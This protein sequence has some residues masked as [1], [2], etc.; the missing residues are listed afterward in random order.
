MFSISILIPVY[1]YDVSILLESLKDQITSNLT[2]VI[3]ID[4]CSSNSKI[5]ENNIEY[6]QNNHFQYDVNN[7]N[8]GRTKT[9]RKL[10]SKANAEKLLFIDV[11]TIVT[12]KD[13]LQKFINEVHNNDVVFGGISYGSLTNYN[14]SLRWKYGINRESRNLKQRN[15]TPYLSVISGCFLIDK[16]K[17][18]KISE[19]LNFNLYGMDVLFSYQMKKLN[20]NV[21]HIDNPI[22]HIGLEQNLDFI[23]KTEK[24][25]DTLTWLSQKKLIPSSYRPIQ[26][27]LSQLKRLKIHPIVGLL[28][29]LFR[30]L[31][32][33]QLSSKSPSLQLFDIYRLGYLCYKSSK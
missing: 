24:G 12:S 14:Y 1:N 11:D 13:F 22:I 3:I 10:A 9:R 32:I 26:I 16:S 28:F 8:L 23:K 25:L 6:C 27:K 20:L 33:K 4:D 21:K 18:L 5:T 7:S 15:K 17:F 19:S 30:P 2:E 31:L 29:K